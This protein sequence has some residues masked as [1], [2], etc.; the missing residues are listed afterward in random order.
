MAL[1][2]GGPLRTVVQASR[3]SLCKVYPAGL[4]ML[5]TGYLPFRSTA[6]LRLMLVWWRT[7]WRHKLNLTDV[8]VAKWSIAEALSMFVEEL[9]CDLSQS[10]S[11]FDCQRLPSQWLQS[12]KNPFAR[13]QT[14]N[15]YD[16]GLRMSRVKIGHYFR[17]RGARGFINPE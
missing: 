13:L 8:T 11:G 16:S 10:H 5:I 2:C 12:W 9:A 7:L 6:S 3:G 1:F 4:V 15:W 17:R 14:L